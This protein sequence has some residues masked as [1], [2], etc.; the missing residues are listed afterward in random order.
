MNLKKNYSKSFLNQ[1]GFVIKKFPDQFFIN[2]IEKIIK[3]F[4][5]KK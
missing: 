2:N 3:K 1:N 5:Y 4:F